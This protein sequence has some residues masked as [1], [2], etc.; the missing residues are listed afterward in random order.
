[1]PR[2]WLCGLTWPLQCA[3]EGKTWL[4]VAVAMEEAGKPPPEL[5]SCL[6]TALERAET[7]GDPRL[8]VRQRG[9]AT[10]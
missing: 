9:T 1:M 10:G 5:C 8:Q 2:V 6:R 3:Q 7:A 4:N